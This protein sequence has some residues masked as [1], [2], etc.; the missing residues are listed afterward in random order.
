MDRK[1]TTK[2]LGELLVIDRLS[3]MGKYWA[4]EVSV[5][6]GTVDVKRVDFV[7]F[8]PVGVTSVGLIEKGIFTCYEIKSCREDV[9]SGNGL[10]FIGEKNYIVTT[11][12]CYKSIQDDIRSGKLD[13]H[14]NK[15]CPSSSHYYGIM[16]AVPRYVEI[17]DEY[18][19]PTPFNTVNGW[20]LKV[21]MPCR[22]GP[23][24]RSLTE[25]LFYMLRSGQRK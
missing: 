13:A 1:R 2:L 24:Q 12:E 18:E 22:Q 14:I 23:R 21:I 9:F 5:D 11:M 7:Q 10:N 8:E 25:M 20:E 4:R 15:C 6:Y 16:V 3:G 19:N 17:T